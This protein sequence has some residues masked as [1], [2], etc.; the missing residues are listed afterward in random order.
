MGFNQPLKDYFNYPEFV[1][2]A[3][4]QIL[5]GIKDRGLF[6]Y[7]KLMKEWESR[8]SSNNV[9]QIPLLWNCLSFEVWAQIFIDKSYS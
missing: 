3:N 8:N 4:D 9:T 6:D 5:P 7:K 2:M 1:E